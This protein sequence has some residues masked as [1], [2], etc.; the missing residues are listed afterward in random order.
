MT[1]T[2]DKREMPC[3]GWCRNV[4]VGGT[5]YCVGVERGKRVRIPY[6]PR[7]HN[8]GYQWWGFVRDTNG[9]DVWSDRVVGSIGAR[10]VLKL[11]GLIEE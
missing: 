6:K 8:M 10:G 4:E 11:A 9:R 3:G 2:S 1:F 7:G 5:R